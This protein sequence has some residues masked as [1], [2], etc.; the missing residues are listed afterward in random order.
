MCGV[1]GFVSMCSK[2]DFRYEIENQ[3]L[4]GAVTGCIDAVLVIIMS[5]PKIATGDGLVCS[6]LSCFAA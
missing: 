5:I 2:E 4:R 1:E 6:G 3:I